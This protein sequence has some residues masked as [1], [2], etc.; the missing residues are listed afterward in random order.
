MS[1]DPTSPRRTHA[2]PP[3][4]SPD[5]SGLAALAKTELHQHLGGSVPVSLT[6]S[7]LRA[8]GL[9]PVATLEE[10]ARLLVVQ[11]EERG[12]A[13]AYFR[14]FQLGLWATQ[15]AENL[16]LAAQRVAAA[17]CACGVT[18]LELRFSPQLHGYLGLS[19]R[20]A[21][22]AVLSGLRRAARE[23]PGLHLGLVVSAVRQLGPD[24]AALLARQAL[25]EREEGRDGELLVG[26]DL[27]GAERGNPAGAFQSSF[28]AAAGGGLGLTAHAGEEDGAG[29]VWA[30]IDELGA[31]RVGHGC[32]ALADREL[33]RRLARDQVLVE[34]CLSSNLDTGALALGAPPPLVRFLEAG[35][36][37]AICTDNATVSATD[38]VRETGLL[39][40]P[41]RLEEL[42]EVH[43]GARA[44]LFG[45]TAGA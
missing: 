43:L 38:Q 18:A 27:C 42:A 39:L 31:R 3:G 22:A 10:L 32:A 28:A 23:A 33:L 17:A 8:R 19:P 35:V 44:H 40:G 13:P 11:P 29:S 24:A 25:V 14:K 45:A 21:M 5:A 1:P 16:T 30:A 36:P 12:S 20:E 2:P 26:F 9:A 6:W 37:V 41:L 4:R 15:Y 7:L 34:C